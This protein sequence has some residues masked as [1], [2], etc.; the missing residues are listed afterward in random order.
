MPLLGEWSEIPDPDREMILTA[1]QKVEFS[2]SETI[3]R[4][5]NDAIAL[6]TKA[7]PNMSPESK[8]FA[9]A[10]IGEAHYLMGETEYF[11]YI[12]SEKRVRLI[13]GFAKENRHWQAAAQFLE[14]AS[15]RSPSYARPP[16]ILAKMQTRRK[17]WPS[18]LLA[19]ESFVRAAPF[20][21]KAYY[22]RGRCFYNLDQDRKA[23]NDF[24]KAVEMGPNDRD[25]WYALVSSRAFAGQVAPAYSAAEQAIGSRYPKCIVYVSLG[26]GFERGGLYR[27]ALS[28]TET[29]IHS[30]GLPKHIA[31]RC[32]QR[33]VRC[34][35]K[36]K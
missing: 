21:P 25:V 36:L 3:E 7:L 18:A 32:E 11:R 12:Q 9:L 8:Y 10:V 15:R 33:I 5:C 23:L 27:E 1:A 26:I 14:D 28:A 34:R 6:A 29:A 20:C 30:G 17:D 19:A 13:D 4:D 35:A 22:R 16:S 24:E 2:T 31:Q